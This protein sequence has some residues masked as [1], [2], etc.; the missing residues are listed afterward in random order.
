MPETPEEIYKRARFIADGD[1]RLPI[2][3]YVAM[4]QFPYEGEFYVKPL[5]EPLVPEPPRRGEDGPAECPRCQYPGD[6]VIWSDD[7]WILATDSQPSGL[8]VAVLLQPK[9]HLDLGQLDDAQAAAMGR[10]IVHLERAIS[11]LDGVARVHVARWGDTDAHLNVFLYARPEGFG[12]FRGA[13]LSLWE[14]I[15][16]PTPEGV[17]RLNHKTV[18]DRFAES[19]GGTVHIEVQQADTSGIADRLSGL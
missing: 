16:P 8:P 6:G 19:Y 12:Q 11:S 1:G 18:A 2:P 14:D 5:I 4:P 7:E 10:M 13:C 17:W 15:L 9:A 3:M